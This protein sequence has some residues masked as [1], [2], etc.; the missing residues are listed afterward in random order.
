MIKP[1]RPAIAGTA[2]E[3]VGD[4]LKPVR[5]G[6]AE[7]VQRLQTDRLGLFHPVAQSFDATR[8][9]LYASVLEDGAQR[10]TLFD[11]LL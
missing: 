3:V 9:I 10:L 8:R 7:P 5:H 6:L 1:F 2:H 4:Q 11:Q